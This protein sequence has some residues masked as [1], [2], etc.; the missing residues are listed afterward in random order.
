MQ[1]FWYL[2]AGLVSGI[3]AGMGMG[4]GTFL[5]PILTILLSVGQRLAQGINLIVFLPMAVIVIIIYAHKKMID[6][7]GWWLISLPSCLVCLL[8]VFVAFKTPMKIL[9]I[10]F[11]AFIILIGIIQIVV[12]I[13]S[14]A[15][16]N[17]LH[18]N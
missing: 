14:L 15:K 6:F 9:K 4:G 17:K 1:F 8:G 18:K 16:K 7:K 2:L 11:A 13:I 3:F 12:M 10:I 5:I